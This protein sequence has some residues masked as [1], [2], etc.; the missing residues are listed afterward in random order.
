MLFRD[1]RP[2]DGGPG[3]ETNV[4][5]R[6]HIRMV[7]MSTDHAA[8]LCLR[9]AVGFGCMTTCRARLAG[10]R[11]RNQHD[12]HA[13]EP[14]LV[15]DERAQLTKSPSA[16]PRPLRLAK[17]CPIADAF[18]VFQGDSAPG[19]FGLGNERFG[20]TMILVGSK[21]PFL[22]AQALELA[23]NVL[24]AKSTP[25]FPRSGF[26]QATAKRVLSNTYRFYC[27]AAVVLPVAVGGDI[28]HSEI[29]ANEIGRWRLGAVWQIDRY[30]QKPFSV[31][32][33]HQIALSFGVG[34]ALFLIFAHDHGHEN[35]PG[36]GQ[37]RDA[38]NAFEAHQPLIVRD[39]S[40]RSKVWPFC[41]VPLVRFADLSDTTYRHLSR[42]PEALTQCGVVE[43]LQQDFVGGFTIERFSSQP[44]GSGIERT[45]GRFER[46]DLFLRRQKL[47]L[48]GQ[49]HVY[50]Y[51]R[52]GSICQPMGP[53]FLPRLKSG[54]SALGVL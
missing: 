45:H 16:H 51:K 15:L 6:V 42:K 11:R 5:R 48:Q 20:N 46:Q 47:C 13:M 2:I 9:W 8:E 37:Q 12:I 4:P 39:R 26:L 1:F 27:I 52:I 33:P 21:S 53:R 25:L 31:F 38:V 30:Q 19:A 23:P 10:V 34:K 41:F 36:K 28:G 7:G 32:A 14:C 54:A 50:N 35:A 29:D 49:F 40:K 22:P 24:G 17:P 44:I 43:F 3:D 18:E